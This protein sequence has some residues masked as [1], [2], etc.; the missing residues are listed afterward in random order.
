MLVKSSITAC[1][2]SE[3]AGVCCRQFRRA[4][5]VKGWYTYCVGP[6]VYDLSAWGNGGP[7]AWS[8]AHSA[9]L[10][11]PTSLLVSLPEF[12][13]LPQWLLSFSGAVEGKWGYNEGAIG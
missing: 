7:G 10:G 13:D 3:C 4:V 11:V 1:G 6:A 5:V 12:G 8:R 9:V 2:S